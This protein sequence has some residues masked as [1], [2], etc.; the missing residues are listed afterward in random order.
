MF[1]AGADLKEYAELDR[2]EA[3]RRRRALLV[4]TLRALLDYPG[5]LVAAVQGKALGAGCMIALLADEVV[6]GEGAAMGLPEIRHGMPTPIG[7]AIVA[8]RAGEA[9]ARRM[10]QGGEPADAAQ[11]LRWGLADEVAADAKAAALARAAHIPAGR[12]FEANKRYIN[13]RLRAALDAA[14]DAAE[15][16]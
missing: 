10:V 15:K 1:S 4:H 9:V 13:G 2:A 8:A 7:H 16:A 3:S 6:I 14:I 5:P 11:C 12:A